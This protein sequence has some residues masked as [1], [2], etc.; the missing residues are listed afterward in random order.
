MAVLFLT[1]LYWRGIVGN[2][3]K[4]IF[5]DGMM[6]IMWKENKLKEGIDEG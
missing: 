5:F 3:M 4:K 1:Y 6:G 2:K